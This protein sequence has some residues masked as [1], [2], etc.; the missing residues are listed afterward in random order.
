MPS[1][2]APQPSWKQEVNRRLAEHKNRKGISVVDQSEGEGG[3]GAANSRAAAAAARVAARY[4]KA[5][6]YS[7]MQA[8]EARAALR[9]AEA[10]TRAALQAQAAAQAALK[11]L[12]ASD[13]EFEVETRERQATS[14]QAEESQRRSA[15]ET[16]ETPSAETQPFQYR[17]CPR[18]RVRRISLILARESG[19]NRRK[20]NEARRLTGKSSSTWK[21]LNRS[22]QISLSFPAS[23][24]PPAGCAPG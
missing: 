2:P 22:T 20:T 13:E 23:W 9:A 3:Q 18:T 1:S 21:L 5:P 16:P 4:A 6:S 11:N 14:A 15:W 19:G 12:E 10:A 17:I 24:S 8:A 7:D